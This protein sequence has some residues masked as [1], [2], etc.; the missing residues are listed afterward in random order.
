MAM[1]EMKMKWQE[2]WLRNEYR[3]IRVAKKTT[4]KSGDETAA[5]AMSPQMQNLVTFL[6]KQMKHSYWDVRAASALAL[7]KIGLKTDPIRLMLEAAVAKDKDKNVQE[8][9]A[10]ALGMLKSNKSA[11]LLR[12]VLTNK[13]KNY[14]LR[15]YCAVALGMMGDAANLQLLN[16]VAKTERKDEVRAAAVTALGLIGDERAVKTL[17]DIFVSRDEARIRALA[18]TAL[19]KIGVTEYKPSRRSRTTINLVREFEKR[20]LNKKTKD[21]VRQ[22]IAM[23]MGRFGDATTVDKLQRVVLTDKDKAVRAFALLSLAQIKKD[24]AK[25]ATVREFLR[26]VLKK[27]KN[28]IVRCYAVLAVG[29]SDDKEAVKIVR[30]IFLKG[31]TADE[32][33]AAAVGLGLLKDADSITML[34]KEIEDPKG[35]G[36]TRRFCCISLGLIGDMAASKYLKAVLEK[37]NVPYLRWSAAIGLA[38][39]G[40]KSCLDILLKNLKDGGRIV[41]EAAI[42]ALGYFRDENQIQTLISSFEK[43]KN[44]EV[45]AMHIVSLGYIGDSAEGVPVLRQVSQ[46]FNW[47]AAVP[48]SSIDFILRVF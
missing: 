25:K 17:L 10:L 31:R 43:E 29:L 44:N 47:I 19:G 6:M 27:E 42:R 20:L 8:S 32:R 38:R 9:A 45:K 46:D 21:H 5:E 23:I 4:I 11:F 18:V 15:S 12:S 39:L 30:N 13:R 22:S 36:D 40:D 16:N 1:E 3:F 33:A 48:Y 35:G 14:H 28:S 37:V 34:A 7:G 41:K 2:W 26:R 24:D